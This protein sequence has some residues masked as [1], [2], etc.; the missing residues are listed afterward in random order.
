MGLQINRNDPVTKEREMAGRNKTSGVR[1]YR[2]TDGDLVAEGD[3]RA[4]F[5]AYAVGTEVMAEKIAEYDAYVAS[6][7]AD[8]LV[9]EPAA[10]ATSDTPIHDSLAEGTD[11]A[12]VRAAF[13]VGRT[14]AGELVVDTDP[15]ATQMAY[16][17]GD[18][19][20]DPAD[21]KAYAA[22]AKSSSD[23]IDPSDDEGAKHAA[24][25]ADKAAAK[26]ANK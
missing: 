4:A 15:L 2:T 7:D 8:T 6:L 3:P 1:C 16:A 18:E 20:V 5:L 21:R 19:I 22:L 14:E 24:K 23:E 17:E 9:P 12:T 26:A 13:H 25:P 11:P 10:G